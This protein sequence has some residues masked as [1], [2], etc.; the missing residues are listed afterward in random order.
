[1]PFEFFAC[2][3]LPL[4]EDRGPVW[5]S[6]FEGLD[7]LGPWEVCSLFAPTGRWFVFYCPVG[8]RGFGLAAP[9]AVMIPRGYEKLCIGGPKTPPGCPEAIVW[10]P[11]QA[12]L[13]NESIS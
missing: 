6:E 8:G 10:S 9:A 13:P 11:N 7:P 5:F 3:K 4:Y 12:P 1:M 2:V